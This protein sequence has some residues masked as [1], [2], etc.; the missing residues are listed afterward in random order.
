M[1]HLE[2]VCCKAQPHLAPKWFMDKLACGDAVSQPSLEVGGSERSRSAS[3]MTIRRNFNPEKRC[4]G[5][6]RQELFAKTAQMTTAALVDNLDGQGNQAC[7]IAAL[8]DEVDCRDEEMD[9]TERSKRE[10][11]CKQ[12]VPTSTFALSHA[13]LAAGAMSAA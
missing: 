9:D 3:E 6:G 8:Q 12:R 13:M 2:V 5:K 11:I 1:G 7:A 4:H 10:A